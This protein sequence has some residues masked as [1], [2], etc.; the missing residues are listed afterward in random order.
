VRRALSA[1]LFV[2]PLS[3]F[4]VLA[5]VV[6]GPSVAAQEGPTGLSEARRR[7][8][9]AAAEI[10][11]LETELGGLDDQIS[12]L[13]AERRAAGEEL[14]ALRERVR[15]L[16]LERY[17]SADQ[18]ADLVIGLDL[19]EHERARA[20]ANIVTQS[21]TD[22]IDEYRAVSARLDRSAADLADR[23]AEQAD[24]LDALQEQR[25]QLD[26][27]LARLEAEEAERIEAERRATA[28]AARRAAAVAAA[29][30]PTSVPAASGG[31]GSAPATATPVPSSPTVTA[32]PVT[33]PSPPGGGGWI[34]P[35]QGARSF[36]DSWGAARPGGRAHQG[37]DLMSPRGTPVVTPV[38]GVVQTKTGGIGGLTFRLEG[39]DGNWYYGAHLDSYSGA[40]G[41]LPAGTVVGTVGDTGDAKGTGTHL[42]FEIHVG[43]YGRPV[44]PYPTVAR[45]C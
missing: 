28:E 45:H 24:A 35:V 34:C 13:D 11:R 10:N 19:N 4:L 15:H 14:G 9:R 12:R 36:V 6:A 41:R 18:Q 2:V 40:S 39:D 42:H 32:P 38:S 7:A 3:V 33:Q 17:T 20:L 25:E 37:V 5:A 30:A 8:D 43:G 31:T 23:Q 1:P 26:R 27:E 21:D 29:V 16:A 44:N 22:A